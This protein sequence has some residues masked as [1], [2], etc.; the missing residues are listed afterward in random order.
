MPVPE[1]LWDVDAEE[2]AEENGSN[3]ND[4][5]TAAMLESW[6]KEGGDPNDVVTMPPDHPHSLRPLM[7]EVSGAGR[8]DLMRVLLARGANPN[9]VDPNGVSCIEAAVMENHPDAVE[10]LMAHGVD[11]L[12]TSDRRSNDEPLYG[13]AVFAGPRIIRMMLRAGADY[14]LRGY[15]WSEEG[16]TPEDWARMKNEGGYEDYPDDPRFA[17]NIAI[18]QAVRLAGSYKLWVLEPHQRLLGLRALCQ[19]G[20]AAPTASTP[21]AAARLLDGVSVPDPIVFHA[22]A[23]YLG[24]ATTF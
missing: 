10:L 18:L 8:C 19:R 9:A 5:V 20:R 4:R 3:T 2:F 24:D 17:Q 7:Q 6:L 1:W 16:M 12:T 22:L 21:T 11:I 14:T 13:A 23:Y 15:S